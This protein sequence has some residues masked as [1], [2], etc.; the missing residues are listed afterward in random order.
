M[1]PHQSGTC[2]IPECP[3]REW[4]SQITAAE[5]KRQRR[6]AIKLSQAVARAESANPLTG[7]PEP[8]ARG[9]GDSESEI[10][11]LLDRLQS[12][13]AA[14]IKERNELRAERTRLIELLGHV[15]YS[16]VEFDDNRMGYVVVQIDR[17]AWDQIKQLTPQATKEPSE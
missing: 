3:C 10:S 15:S 2:V 9:G 4:S 6:E 13:W 1:D 11:N 17:D 5:D 8:A 7:E 12:D 16:G 14:M